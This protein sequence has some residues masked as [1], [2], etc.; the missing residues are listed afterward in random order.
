MIDRNNMIF[1]YSYLSGDRDRDR[2]KERDSKKSAPQNLA[3]LLSNTISI[4]S[5]YV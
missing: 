2:D 4:Y 5:Q 1:K 3:K